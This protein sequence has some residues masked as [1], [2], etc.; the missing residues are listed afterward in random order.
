MKKNDSELIPWYSKAGIYDDV[1]ISSKIKIIRNLGD[2]VFPHL[3]DEEERQRVNSLL[4]DGLVNEKNDKYKLEKVDV[5]LLTQ[6][7]LKILK[8]RNILT[9]N[10]CDSV[11]MNEDGSFFCRINDTDHLHIVSYSSGLDFEKLMENA[12]YYDE[13]LQKKV[14]FAATFDFGYLCSNLQDTGTGLKLSFRCFIPA[15]VF[16]KNTNSI[17]EKA[18][19][20]NLKIKYV[21]TSEEKSDFPS[22]I[23]EVS[24]LI[25]EKGTEFDQMAEI[26]SF[27][28]FILKTE[29]KIRETFA[30]NNN[31]IVLN[32]VKQ[33]YAKG[34]SSIFL[35]YK[36]AV[37]II[38]A[39]KFGLQCGYIT[40]I[41]ESELNG[42]LFKIQDAHLQFLNRS[43]DFDFEE[44][45]K[46][47]KILQI[48][49][50]R[51]VV[52]QEI[53]EKIK[54]IR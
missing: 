6:E 25:S 12:Y 48:Q 50:L 36:D 51:S 40:G 16:S 11:F 15:I 47:N 17:I 34:L 38:S 49:R 46:K 43:Y 31:M 3:M 54:F 4:S 26:K 37:C 5:N 20:N 14:Q 1:F 24:T 19:Q 21:F 35:L 44:D 10:R 33:A 53:F 9:Q 45:I 2:F 22:S 13:K 39:I 18:V 23:Y 8:E 7:G 41:E 28:Q 52:I 42:L 27:A 32:F 30:D 29:R